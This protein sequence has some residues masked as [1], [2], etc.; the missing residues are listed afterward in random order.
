[1]T[2]KK[3]TPKDPS[4]ESKAVKGA[5]PVKDPAEADPSAKG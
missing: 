1:M 3:V 4:G 2:T 5:K